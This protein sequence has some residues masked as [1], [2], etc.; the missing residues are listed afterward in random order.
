[1]KAPD[2]LTVRVLYLKPFKTYMSLTV[3]VQAPDALTIRRIARHLR[4]CG[5]TCL[6]FRNG[7]EPA[8]RAT[9]FE[10]ATSL[11]I[12]CDLEDSQGQT[13]SC[14]GRT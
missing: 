3:D 13:R 9:L 1:M 4:A 2:T 14:C 11:S 7:R 6:K 5:L 8:L 10:A 12:S